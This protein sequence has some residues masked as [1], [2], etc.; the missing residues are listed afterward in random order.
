MTAKTLVDGASPLNNTGMNSLTCFRFRRFC[1]QISAFSLVLAAA[2]VGTAEDEAANESRFLT[3]TRQL[4]F[5]GLRSGEGYFSAD[6]R[7]MVFQ[8][9]RDP[10]NP[11]Y[12]IYLLDLETG[13]LD[14][15]SPGTGKTTCAWIHSDGDRVLFASTHDDREAL[16]KQ[17][18]ELDFRASG[19]ERR[20]SW[21]YDPTYELYAFSKRSGEYR[22]LTNARGYDAEG[23]YSPDGQT[24]VFASNRAAYDRVLTDAEAALLERD[25]S[26]F[27]DLYRCDANGSNIE[28][29]TDT[30][31]Y[32]GGPFFSPDGTQICWRRFNEDGSQAEIMTAKLDGTDVRQ[33]TSLQ[34]MSWAPYFHPSGEYLIFTTNLQGFANFEL[35]LVRADGEG[36]PVRVTTT[37]GFDGLPVFTPNGN[38]VSWTSNRTPSKK[39]QIFLADWNHAAARTALGLDTSDLPET[40]QQAIAGRPEYSPAEIAQHVEFLASE[41][42]QGRAS[43]SEG[44]RLATEYIAS[45]FEAI[46]L[47][48]AGAITGDGGGYFDPFEFTAGVSLGPKNSLTITTT[49]GTQT[50]SVNDDFRPLAFSAT[51]QFSASDVVFAGYGIQAPADEANG[52]D[53]YDSFVHLDVKDKWVLVLRFLPDDVTAE[54]RQQLSRH[55]SLRRKAMVARDLGAKGLLVFSGPE[56]KVKQELISLRFDGSL[57]GTSV[58]VLSITDAVAAKVLGKSVDEIG[59]LQTKLDAGELA[60]GTLLEG[61]SIAASVDIAQQQSRDRNVLGVLRAG[62]EP[63]DEFV[64]VGAH[65]DHLGIGAGGSSLARDDERDGIH[66][67]A[68]DNASGVAAM[69]EIAEATAAAK[70]EGLTMKRDV[71]FAAWSAEELGLLGASRFLED[72]AAAGIGF[73]PPPATHSHHGASP[74]NDHG[75]GAHADTH[76]ADHKGANAGAKAHAHGTAAANPH[77]AD[78]HAKVPHAAHGDAKHGAGQKHASEKAADAHI[79]DAHKKSPHEHAHAAKAQGGDHHGGPDHGSHEAG[80]GHHDAHAGHHAMSSQRIVACLNLDMVG[81][82]RDA[83]VLQGVGSSDWW[84]SQIERRNVPVGLPLTLS[85]DSYIPTDASAFYAR[86]VP[87]LAAFTGSHEDYHTPRDTA[88]K[89]NY[90]GVAKIARLMG[91]ITR[92]LVTA[93]APPSYVQQAKPKDQERRANLRAYLGTVPDYAQGDI[94]GVKLSG[95][96]KGGPAETGGVRGGDIIV[97]LAGKKIENIYDYTFAIEALK[98][99]EEVAITV[100]RDGKRVNLKVT[101]GSR[102]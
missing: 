32:D 16:G 25:P 3:Q 95:V 35:Y 9:E 91:L 69:L 1:L 88:D 84:P 101:P 21:D 97:E 60:M 44:N 51:G 26:F 59:E 85:N 19:K 46:G 75:H 50:L 102:D 34:A 73:G 67:G 11:F 61:T 27:I 37:D 87:I 65:I 10:A 4:T 90:D 78:P 68:D 83:L 47:Q 17:Q 15:V 98:I 80:H 71:V 7:K 38:Q 56:S 77:A 48:P 96:A 24:I 64:I 33:L 62:D 94:I 45:H 86:G 22:R 2:G 52:L 63:T 93:A 23:S 82:L 66:Y 20:Y 49:D 92:S 55:A 53:E 30:P 39:S 79:P 40:S 28:R 81:R 57:S 6:G 29:L 89:I 54:R 31:G 18:A 36:E 13:D 41:R 100:Q 43:G 74:H 70:A 58:A 5:E 42:L 72:V 76:A 8:S 12:Q 99:G 14:K